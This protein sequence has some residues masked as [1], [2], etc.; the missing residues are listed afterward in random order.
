MALSLGKAWCTFYDMLTAR[1]LL[2]EYI[3]EFRYQ[4]EKVRTLRL[5]IFFHNAM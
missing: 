3:Y 2:L 1:A 5:S 4:Y